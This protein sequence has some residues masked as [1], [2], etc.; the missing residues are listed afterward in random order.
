MFN[1]ISILGAAIH[2]PDF[3]R[4]ERVEIFEQTFGNDMDYCRQESPW[5]LVREHAEALREKT[6][7][8]HV[9]EKD[10]RLCAKNIDFHELMDTLN[11]LHD[12]SVVPDAGHN[13]GQ[14][15]DNVADPWAFYRRA[16]GD[17]EGVKS[18]DKQGVAS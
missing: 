5:M 6:I 15:L 4:E 13:S 1:A 12:F 8:L 17:D 14:V 10:E 7:R 18:D 16:F 3:L 9:G 2:R 11:I